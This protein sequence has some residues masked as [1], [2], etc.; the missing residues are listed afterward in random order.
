[1]RG[2]KITG[3]IVRRVVGPLLL[4]LS[5][6]GAWAVVAAAEGRDGWPSSAAVAAA[7]ASI[8]VVASGQ[9]GRAEVAAEGQTVPAAGTHAV[10]ET[11]KDSS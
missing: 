5:T 9:P 2:L 4:V 11:A 1:M 6:A 7:A 3:S 8:A 10:V